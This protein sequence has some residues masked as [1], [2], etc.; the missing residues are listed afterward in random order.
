[1]SEIEKSKL[2]VLSEF[3]EEIIRMLPCLCN[4][5]THIFN[6]MLLCLL[7]NIIIYELSYLLTDVITHQ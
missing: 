6:N 5:F 3:V 4:Y 1:M 7:T 2:N